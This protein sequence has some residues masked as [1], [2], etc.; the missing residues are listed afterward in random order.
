MRKPFQLAALAALACLAFLSSVHG[1]APAAAAGKTFIDYFLPIPIHGSLSAD[2]WGAPTVLPRD[3]KNGLEDATIKEWCYWD[4]QIIK[5]K[6][7]TYHMFA[8]RWPQANGHNGWFGSLA[9]HAV[10]ERT[11]PVPTSTRALSGPTIKA[12]KGTT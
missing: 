4:G 9:V 8:S 1:Q 12:E 5:A 11:S 6:D 10:S 3:P 7:G 2:A